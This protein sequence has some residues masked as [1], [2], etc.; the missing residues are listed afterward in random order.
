MPQRRVDAPVE[1]LVERVD[2]GDGAGHVAVEGDRGLL[3]R[4]ARDGVQERPPTSV[5]GVV[6]P[7]ARER[8]A[9][10]LRGAHSPQKREGAAGRLFEGL[11]GDGDGDDVVWRHSGLALGHRGDTP[12]PALRREPRVAGPRAPVAAAVGITTPRQPARGFRRRVTTVRL[13][14]R[15]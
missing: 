5:F 10:R 6:V 3:R 8:E 4:E 1:P 12:S 13:P 14:R 15:T 2:V 11:V 9:D 7:D